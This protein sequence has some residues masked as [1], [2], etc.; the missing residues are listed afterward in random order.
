MTVTTTAGGSAVLEPVDGADRVLQRYGAPA[1]QHPSGPP[2]P[3]PNP[4]VSISPC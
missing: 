4:I 2:P 3:L 1:G